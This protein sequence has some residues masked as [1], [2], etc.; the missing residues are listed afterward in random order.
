MRHASINVQVSPGIEER[1]M[2]SFST[3]QPAPPEKV[4][5]DGVTYQVAESRTVLD[6][7][8]DLPWHSGRWPMDSWF[9]VSNLDSAGQRIGFQV[10]FLIQS[11]PTGASVVQLNVVVVNETAGVSRNFEYLYQ[12]EQIELSADRMYINTPELTF[13]GDRNG[14]AV[15]VTGQDA[16]IDITTTTAA[17]P[18]LMNGQGQFYFLDL[19]E[20]YEF[21][22]PAMPTTGTVVIGEVNYEVSGASWLDRQWGGLPGVFAAGLS[23]GAPALGADGPPPKV[24]NWIWSNPQLDNGVNV[25]VAQI[26]D[27]INNKIYLVLTAVHPDGTHV[28]VPRMEPVEMGEYWTSPATGHRYPTRCVFRAPQIDTELIVEVPYKQQEIVS[29][30]DI[31]TKFE[32]TASFT[33]TYQGQPVTGYGYLELVGNWS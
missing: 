3:D 12:L 13:S 9:L 17:P 22:F 15:R 28:V 2:A 27:M 10:H 1:K 25:A 24:M 23:G 19:D 4:T 5:L 14:C 11:L 33:G 29:A 32:G 7:D 16:R 20:Q 21:A 18:V 6:I 8:R 31:L 26:R 30:V